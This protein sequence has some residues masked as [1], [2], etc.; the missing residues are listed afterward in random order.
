MLA[1]CGGRL[2]AAEQAA[3][4]A[5]PPLFI[6]AVIVLVGTPALALWTFITVG[7][8]A[9]SAFGWRLG[10]SCRAR[11][12]GDDLTTLCGTG[13]CRWRRHRVPACS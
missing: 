4:G 3:D 11:H 10:G 13:D 6:S 9:C 5:L 7:A 1:R 12:R 2:D 8:A